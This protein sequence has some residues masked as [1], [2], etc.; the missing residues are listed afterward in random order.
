MKLGWADLVLVMDQEHKVRILQRFGKSSGLGRIEVLDIEDEYQYMDEEL[1][2]MIRSG[3]DGF[4]P[5]MR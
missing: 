2:E 4:Y 1:V 3:C 5:S